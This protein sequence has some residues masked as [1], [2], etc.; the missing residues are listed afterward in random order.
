MA[1]QAK[2]I[3]EG[4]RCV[5]AES[6]HGFHVYMKMWQQNEDQRGLHEEANL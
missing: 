4:T 2:L 3:E 1:Y 6:F 5:F